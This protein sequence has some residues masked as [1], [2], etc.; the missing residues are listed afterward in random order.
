MKI[1][2]ITC[3][4][5]FGGRQNWVFVLVETDAG[6]T[7]VGEAS[8]EGKEK[9][10][11]A[12]VGDMARFIIGRDPT[13]I[14]Q[15]WQIMYRHGFWRGGV[16]LM[17]AMSGIDQA[18]WDIV[19]KELGVPVYRLLGGAARDRMELYTHVHGRTPD[20]L[21]VN[22]AA[23]VAKGWRALKTGSV[24]FEQFSTEQQAVDAFALRIKLMRDAV[25]PEVKIMVDAHGKHTPGQAL[26][27]IRA[28]AP[29]DLYFF[30]EPVPPDNVAA[31][32]RVREAETGVTLATGERLFSKWEYHELIEKQLVDIVQ[33]DICHDGGVTESLKIA[34]LAE[35]YY[36]RVAPHNPNGPVATAASLQLAAALPGFCILEYAL[37]QPWRDQVIMQPLE[38]VNGYV[39]LPAAPGLGV[40]L[41]MAGIEKLPYKPGDYSSAFWP[42]GGVADI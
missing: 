40:E 8:L 26:K 29:Y 6:V 14:Q 27:L 25:G 10:V 35:T 37:N 42:D 41:N 4:L 9:A 1:T 20:E 32:Q 11:E 5:A 21:A 38:I 16:V 12:A 31:Y 19:G 28:V 7:G 13:R 22:S 24:S 18:L 3:K 30:E 17:T 15:A 33:P 34:A 2:N 39:E 36:I 23:L